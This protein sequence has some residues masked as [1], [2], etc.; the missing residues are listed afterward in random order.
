MATYAL[1]R[2]STEE[3][4]EE[5]QL[6]AMLNLGIPKANIVIEKES[7]KST[8]RTK[9]KNLVKRLRSGD[10]LYIEN[11]DRLSRDYDGILTEWHNLTKIKGVIIKVLDTP[12]L[13]T[14]NPASD[15]LSR[16]IRNNIL[17]TLAFN[18]ELE[19]HRIKKRQA[20][21]IANAK[22]KGRNLGRPKSV[23]TEKDIRVVTQ[24]QAQEIALDIAL[25]LLDIK[26]SAFYN[27]CRAVNEE[28]GDS[29]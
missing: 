28:R 20:E 11:I 8:V 4:N 26:K 24:Y 18:A 6:I 22:A 3:Q 13:D 16:F 9:Y 15:L 12:L 14:D 23:I 1:I 17:H 29:K 21:G 19:W 25:S 5:R 2:V 7:G 27:L 10:T